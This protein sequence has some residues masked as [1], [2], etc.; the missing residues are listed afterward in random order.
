MTYSGNIQADLY[1]EIDQNQEEMEKQK[2]FFCI[3]CEIYTD[4]YG[5]ELNKYDA[6]DFY[7]IENHICENCQD[8]DSFDLFEELG[9][10]LN[11]NNK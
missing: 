7:D 10:N 6:I 2:A 11:P 1:Y 9:K 5:R 4:N 3:D 8:H